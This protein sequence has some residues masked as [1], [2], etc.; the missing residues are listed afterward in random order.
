MRVKVSEATPL[1]LNWM[2]SLAT[3]VPVTLNRG[4]LFWTGTNHVADPITNWSQGGPIFSEAGI[5]ALF[6]AGSAC[7]KPSWFATPNDQSISTSYEGESFD[8]TFMVTERPGMYGPTELIAK[9][10]CFVASRLGD[11]VEVPE[12]LK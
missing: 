1:Q 6:D 7:R 9:A 10:R 8:P 3:G 5:G 12:D 2:V 4:V 11:E